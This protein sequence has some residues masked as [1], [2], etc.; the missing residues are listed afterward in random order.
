[1]AKADLAVGAGGGTTWE[2]LCMGLPSLVLSIAENQIPACEALAFS[3]LIRYLGGAHDLDVAEIESALIESLALAGQL[4]V[5]AT[6][7]QTLVDGRGVN[8]VAEALN[9]TPS[10]H[11]TLRPANAND[12][13]TYFAWVNDPV[14][15][16][17]AINSAPINMATHLQWFDRRLSDVNTHLYVLEA[18]GLPVGQIRFERHGEEVTI[19]YSLDV[20]VRGRGWASQLL[21]LGIEAYK[22]SRPAIFSATV[23]PENIASAATFIRLGFV[24]QE[25]DMINGNRHFQLCYMPRQKEE[26]QQRMGVSNV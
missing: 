9:P 26:C 13:L 3:G 19:D 18:G 25:V 14:N 4:S 21:R 22:S 23:K 2:R 5:L 8:R 11:L 6:G 24:E 10:D 12:A 17:S 7:N 20:L 1:M 16:S 15:R